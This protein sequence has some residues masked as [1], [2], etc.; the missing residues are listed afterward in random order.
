MPVNT[1]GTPVTYNQVI[2]SGFDR[3]DGSGIGAETLY[4]G[5]PP[6]SIANAILVGINAST[7][8]PNFIFQEYSDSPEIE[9][10]EQGTLVH[11][12]NC[13][14]QTGLWIVNT[15]KR[16]D[17]LVDSQNNFTRIL[18]LRLQPY[19]KTAAK[20]ANLTI[21]TESLSF[22]S[23]PDEFDVQ[24]VELNPALEKHPRYSAMS[25]ANRLTVD[26]LVSTN[27]GDI[28]QLQLDN[29]YSMNSTNPA[30]CTQSLEL[31]LKK[32]KGEDS[33]YLN[34]YKVVWS[35]YYWTPPIINPGNYLEDPFEDGG[36]PVYFWSADQT[37]T[38][39]NIFSQTCFFNQNMYPF[40]DSAGLPPY[41]LS[42]LRQTDLVTLNRTWYKITRSWLGA[43]L[44]SWDNELYNP[45]FQ[46][47]VTSITSL[48]SPIF[49]A[50]T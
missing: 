8:N 48:A 35:Q 43:P 47:Y 30:A 5:T 40:V 37:P 26:Q 11:K 36:L 16:G 21:T 38:G 42:W 39:E 23:P 32:F 46:P 29:I 33:F 6:P 18:I 27:N 2:P 10:S 24:L 44:S 45:L 25:Y 4:A 9:L 50:P 1:S 14:W 34:A 49:M 15:F 7:N 3:A 17:V 41:G 31:A 22:N 20:M 28:S 12:F 13:D 19:Q